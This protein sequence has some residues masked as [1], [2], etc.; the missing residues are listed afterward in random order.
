MKVQMLWVSDEGLIPSSY[1]RA[2]NLFAEPL[3][4]AFAYRPTPKVNMAEILE[5]ELVVFQRCRSLRSL[6][7]FL[8]ARCAMRRVVYDIDDYLLELPKESGCIFD[9]EAVENMRLMIA[10]ADLVTC[11][12]L[13]LAEKLRDLNANVEVVANSVEPRGRLPSSADQPVRLFIS[14][15]D[16]FK[17]TF[18]REPFFRAIGDV[19]EKHGAAQ[20]VVVGRSCPEVAHLQNRFGSRVIV[21]E[22]FIPDYNEYLQL[23]ESVQPGI[24]LVPLE[25][26]SF[27]SF[28][29]NIKY[30]DFGAFG[31]PAIFSD[32]PPYHDSIQ[33]GRT[34]ILTP[35]TYEGWFHAM[36]RLIAD[37]QRRTAMGM[38]A[39]DDV[40]EN[41]HK[42]DR[43]MQW[44]AIKS[45]LISSP[46]T[47]AAVGPSIE[48]ILDRLTK[49][50]P[51]HRPWWKRLARRLLGVLPPCVQEGDLIRDT[52]G[53]IFILERG[54]RRHI[55]NPTVFARHGFETCNVQNIGR[56]KIRLFPTG[57][58]LEE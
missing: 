33:H 24:G 5:A 7:L 57:D 10:M 12:T 39:L 23:L 35:N 46:P 56:L 2:V 4:G 3:Q 58:P 19:L 29:S 27:H 38:T 16:Y 31:I 13:P 18:S 45:R 37:P 49:K 40:T 51:E 1:I 32:V 14:N 44:N 54:C 9:K 22:G 15:T 20:M 42:S 53:R 6:C 28:K 11:S 21:H 41:F 55:V 34:G 25:A 47:S 43:T 26:S 52:S 30:L 36:D 8:A 17:L 50:E 48:A